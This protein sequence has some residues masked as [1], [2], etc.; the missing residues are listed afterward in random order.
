[1]VCDSNLSPVVQTF[2]RPVLPFVASRIIFWLEFS[3]FGSCTAQLHNLGV[4]IE[5]ITVYAAVLLTYLF[6]SMLCG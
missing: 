3:S 5:D 2:H 6:G 4:A 1:M